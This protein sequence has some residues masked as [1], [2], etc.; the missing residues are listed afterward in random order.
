MPAITKAKMMWPLKSKPHLIMSP[1]RMM[2][3]WR[4]KAVQD[5]ICQ[6]RPSRKRPWWRRMRYPASSIRLFL[7]E[8][9]LLSNDLLELSR[10]TSLMTHK[11]LYVQGH[12]ALGCKCWIW[13]RQPMQS[14]MRPSR[15]PLPM[16]N[17]IVH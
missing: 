15:M 17:K 9:L 14:W 12:P 4:T 10:R 3:Q 2:R 8:L 6:K 11:M 16:L 13:M 1:S 7:I 5:E